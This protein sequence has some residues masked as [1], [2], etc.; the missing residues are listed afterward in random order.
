MSSK[1]AYDHLVLQLRYHTSHEMAIA[2]CSAFRSIL[3][4]RESNRRYRM[5]PSAVGALTADVELLTVRR[6]P[7]S[8][9]LRDCSASSMNRLVNLRNE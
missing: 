3:K 4:T 8:I 9:S 7:A 6:S 1:T 5:K 2:A